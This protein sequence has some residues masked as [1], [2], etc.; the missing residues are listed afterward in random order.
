M[1]ILGG[2]FN[3]PLNPLTDTSSGTTSVPY[4]ALKNIK[5]NL[6][7]MAL[8]DTW[9]LLNPA[10]KDFTFYSHPLDRY[11]R[12]DYLLLSQSDLAYVQA[13]SIEPMVISDHHPVTLTLRLPEISEKTYNPS[14]LADP[15]LLEDVQSCLKL[16]FIE[17]ST[18]DVA[19]AS[20]WEAHKCVLRGKL[21]AIAASV[22]RRQ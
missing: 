11:S 7:S 13:V 10:V 15:L 4:R 3:I 19:P 20:I 6:T 8:Q 9:R 17:N 16:Y 21:M 18:P 5:R 1:T 14:L 2:D 22:R 12:I